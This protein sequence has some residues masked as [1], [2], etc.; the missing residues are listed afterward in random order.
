MQV[1]AWKIRRAVESLMA[2]FLLAMVAGMGAVLAILIATLHGRLSWNM[3]RRII[4]DTAYTSVSLSRRGPGTAETAVLDRVHEAA[5]T[6][7]HNRYPGRGR[8]AVVEAFET[9]G[10]HDRTPDLRGPHPAAWPRE[11]GSCDLSEPALERGRP[12][13]LGAGDHRRRLRGEHAGSVRRC[14]PRPDAR[15]G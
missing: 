12:S 15:S 4:V 2:L 1:L 11:V 10:P 9:V 13:H 5:L 7:E 3:L 14:A 6:E 8:E